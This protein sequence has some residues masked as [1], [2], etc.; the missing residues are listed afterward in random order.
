MANKEVA[1]KIVV[2]TSEVG[3]G[4]EK[5]VKSVEELGAAT[6]KTSD[7]MKSGFK[8]AEQG[9]KGLGSSIG[10]LLK[11]LG[12]IGVAMAVFEFLKDI[13][14]KNQKVAD[15]L[16]VAFKTIEIMMNELFKAI[17]P[18]GKILKSA[19]ENPQQAIKD[20]ISGVFNRFIT[21]LK[22]IGVVAEG[23]GIQIKG[24]LTLDFDEVKRGLQQY[25]QGLA[26]VATG[27]DVET[28][29]RFID[30]IKNVGSAAIDTASKIQELTKDVKL[31][32]AQQRLLMLQYQ[33]E[34][35]IQRQIRDD[36]S[37]T[38]AQRQEANVKIGLI[39]DKQS[40]EELGL[41]N[42]KKELAEL[43]LSI[44]KDSIDN[45]VE[46]INAETELADVRERITGQRSEQLVNTNSLIREHTEALKLQTEA[47]RVEAEAEA[48]AA[49]KIVE[50]KI[51]AE[52]RLR[53]YL[54]ERESLSREEMIQKEIDDAIAAEEAKFQAAV[55]AAQEL[56]QLQEEIDNLELARQD[57][58]FRLE[59][60]IRAKWGEEQI[61]LEQDIADKTEA[62]RQGDIK[63]Q[64]DAAAISLG[65][66]QKETA[67]K[68]KLAFDLANGISSIVSGLAGQSK[69]A[70]AIQK[71]IAIAQIAVD[72][73]Q[74]ISSAIAG[75][76]ASAAATGVGAVVA[77]PVF[78]A[79]QIAT[80]L[81]AVGQAIGVL[82]SANVGGGSASLPNINVSAASAAPPSF[83]P[84]TTNTTE[85]GNTEQAELAPI[86]AFVVETQVTGSQNNVGQIEGQATFGNPG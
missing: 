50:A 22:G 73:A 63:K 48:E 11:S 34:A 10:G 49:F 18:V 23:V 69:A 14:M 42:K 12:L 61:K 33:R 32:E 52:E 78:I 15:A 17:E 59:N 45:Q 3:E 29:N 60:E 70:V 80:V 72:T 65:A 25:A 26:Q 75:A 27:M 77:T 68:I 31:A 35:E 64:K 4:V 56:G 46:V 66:A 74:S 71:T 44:N 83:N 40:E 36:V 20:L 19:F 84:V 21:S 16:G 28:Q 82:N 38:I 9:T 41:F 1:F 47:L 51:L 62:I 81:S 6:K 76:T 86:Q 37:L 39:L 43:E 24:A 55:N 54:S 7:Q 30:G 5:S 85:L 57:E 13:I 58:L 2:D 8:A 67:A 79:T 53:A